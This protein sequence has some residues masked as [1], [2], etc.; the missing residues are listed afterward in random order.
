M[1]QI[2]AS[3]AIVVIANN[4][5]AIKLDSFEV[6]NGKYEKLL[7]FTFN[8]SLTLDDHISDICEKARF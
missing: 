6:A 5:I 3:T 4:C 1:S 2:V 7:S 8:R